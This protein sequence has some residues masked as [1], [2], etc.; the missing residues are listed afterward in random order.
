MISYYR[1][2]EPVE[3]S[4]PLFRSYKTGTFSTVDEIYPRWSKW[5][6]EKWCFC[7]QTH[8]ITRPLLLDNLILAFFISS[9]NLRQ[10]NSK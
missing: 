3:T 5:Q 2:A 9:V 6:E 7:Y 8:A 4:H 1:Y 10:I